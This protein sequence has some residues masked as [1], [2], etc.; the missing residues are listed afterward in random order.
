MVHFRNNGS[1]F[2]NHEVM[3]GTTLESR[4][5]D[6]CIHVRAKICCFGG[7]DDCPRCECRGSHVRAGI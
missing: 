7:L 1:S 4:V 3:K 2:W 6:R 5:K